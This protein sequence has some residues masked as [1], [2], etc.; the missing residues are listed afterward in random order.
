METLSTDISSFNNNSLVKSVF[1]LI[2]KIT[3]IGL[4]VKNSYDCRINVAV[5]DH[6][7]S[8][9]VDLPQ[10]ILGNKAEILGDSIAE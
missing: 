4:W 9:D 10:E 8:G 2:C 5:N 7:P 1:E 3:A 6:T